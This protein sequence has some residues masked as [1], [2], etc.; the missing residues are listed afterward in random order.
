MESAADP[1]WIIGPY[2]KAI[3]PAPNKM[4]NEN[5]SRNMAVVY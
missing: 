1:C 3:R 5:H 4:I 2:D